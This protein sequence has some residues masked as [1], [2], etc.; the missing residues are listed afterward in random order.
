M[1]ADWRAAAPTANVAFLLGFPSLFSII[2]PIG[3]RSSSTP[4][5]PRARQQWASSFN[6]YRSSK[7][8]EE[9]DG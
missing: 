9:T 1:I 7:H 4:G 6:S 5:T 3:E 8:K 2:N